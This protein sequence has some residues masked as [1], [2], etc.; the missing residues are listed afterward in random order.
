MVVVAFVEAIDGFPAW[1]VE[2]WVDGAVVAGECSADA[3][4]DA[5]EMSEMEGW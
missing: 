4:E 1:F 2:G 5:V 3:P